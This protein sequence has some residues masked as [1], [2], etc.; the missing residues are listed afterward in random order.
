[1][2]LTTAL[3][4]LAATASPALAQGAD[5]YLD[6]RSTAEAVVSSYYN[7]INRQEYARAYA[8]FGQGNEP[9]NYAQW[10][11]GYANTQ[12]VTVQF[13]NV[14]PDGAA[15]STYYG[16]PVFLSVQASSGASHFAGC[17]TVRL[18]Q[19]AIQEPPFTPMHIES[20]SLKAAGANAGPPA[21][22]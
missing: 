2:R 7:A 3:V 1:M 14:V 11:A 15:G 21:S 4:L 16:V 8:Y 19:P 5:D 12:A 10:K 22:C 6:D 13:A 20:A 17:Y 9:S 18:S